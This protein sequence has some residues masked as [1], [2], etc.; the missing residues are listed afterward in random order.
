[1]YATACS[2][3]RTCARVRA[4]THTHARQTCSP[5]NRSTATLS[6]YP[7]ILAR[8]KVCVCV[9]ACGDD[10]PTDRATDRPS[11]PQPPPPPP[12]GRSFG[13][14]ADVRRR[15]VGSGSTQHRCQ[16]IFSTCR[17][18]TYP[19]LSSLACS[20]ARS[21]THTHTHIHTSFSISPHIRRVVSCNMPVL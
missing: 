17:E 16:F 21:S 13:A 19:T 18:C 10:R 5:F 11:P 20:V 4:H 15:S 9:Y 6:A 2:I 3:L 12:S 8:F 1:M 14:A 7:R